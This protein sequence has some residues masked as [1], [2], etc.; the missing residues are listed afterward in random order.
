MLRCSIRQHMSACVGI[1]RHT[2][3]HVKTRQQTS[4]HVST[5]QHTPAYVS[6]HLV[7]YF[8][9]HPRF[10]LFVC[11]HVQSMHHTYAYVSIHRCAMHACCTHTLAA[12]YPKATWHMCR[13]S[14]GTIEAASYCIMRHVLETL[15]MLANACWIMPVLG[16][17]VSYRNPI[18]QA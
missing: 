16:R 2:S 4:A 17:W 8:V 1:R 10:L 14:H 5:S 11:W 15:G 13:V 12:R 7:R 18:Y 9:F 6:I 3:A